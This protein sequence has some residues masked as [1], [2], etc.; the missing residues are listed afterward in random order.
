MKHP[1]IHLA[2]A[3]T[4]TACSGAEPETGSDAGAPATAQQEAAPANAA[5]AA[6]APA[7]A[8]P[9]LPAA[10]VPATIDPDVAALLAANPKTTVL[11]RAKACIARDR[12]AFFSYYGSEYRTSYAAHPEHGESTFRHICGKDERPV[13]SVPDMDAI[14][15]GLALSAKKTGKL[16]N[17]GKYQVYWLCLTEQPQDTCEDAD[18]EVTLENG[19]VVYVTD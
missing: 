15:A 17:L 10:A 1:L 12:A 2:L 11:G 6:P 7:A 9:G 16:D 4:L 18:H 13:P 14:V 5:V 3:V 19:R 8:N